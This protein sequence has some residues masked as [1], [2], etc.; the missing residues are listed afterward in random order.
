MLLC[1]VCYCVW[2]VSVNV[3]VLFVVVGCVVVC[4]WIVV[5]VFYVVWGGYCLFVASVFVCV[6]LCAWVFVL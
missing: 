1:C 2:L 3:C 4:L 6:V 5:S